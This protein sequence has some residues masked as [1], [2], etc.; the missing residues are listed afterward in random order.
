MPMIII[1]ETAKIVE[2]IDFSQLENKT[3]LV[4]GASGLVGIFMLSCLKQV[5]V[6]YNITIYAWVKNEIDP[7]FSDIVEGC[8][9]IKED[10]TNINCFDLLPNFDVIIHA[11]GYGQPS[12][13]LINKLKTI[14]LNTISTIK[15]LDKLNSDGK[16]LFISSSEL[17]S[18]IDSESILETEIGNTN[19]NHFRSC[20]IEGK[21]C[22]EAIC[23][24]YIERGVNVKIARLS[25]AYGPGTKKGDL[26]VMHTLIQKGLEN[27]EIMLM[28]Q[29]EAIRTYCYITDAVEMFWNIL[30][31]GKEVLYNIGGTSKTSILE[32]A[33]LIGEKLDKKVILPEISHELSGNPKVVNI[34]LTKYLNEFKKTN[35]IPLEEGIIETI[36]WQKILYYGKL[37]EG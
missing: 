13:F 32:L 12:K 22:G 10:I 28:D 16:F 2:K 27:N 26:R 3:V 7:L 15:L 20:Y 25:L 14:E 18:G 37:V 24:S 36:N 34:S 17:Y 5:K 8:N 6:K 4:T 1:K 33:T 19:T 29:G 31:F 11:A 9:I 21:R 30:F 35:F 23:Y